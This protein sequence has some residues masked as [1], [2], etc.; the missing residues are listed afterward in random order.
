MTVKT[1]YICDRCH[2]VIPTVNFLFKMGVKAQA[3]QYGRKEYDSMEADWCE[4][5]VATAGFIKR[6][7][8]PEPPAKITMEDFIR[9]IAEEVVANR[10]GG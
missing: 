10:V 5:C 1:T 6:Q 2:E 4:R 9:E 7:N 8:V 3:Y